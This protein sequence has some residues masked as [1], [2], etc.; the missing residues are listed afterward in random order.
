MRFDFSG[1]VGN[2]IAGVD[3]KCEKRAHLSM[4][5]VKSTYTCLV[6]VRS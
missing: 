1:M 3:N 6:K 2:G 4:Q 5:M